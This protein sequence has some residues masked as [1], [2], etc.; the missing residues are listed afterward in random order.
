M[1]PRDDDA[2][3]LRVISSLANHVVEVGGIPV[4]NHRPIRFIREGSMNYANQRDPLHSHA[5]HHRHVFQEVLCIFLS[6]E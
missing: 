6:C 4:P 3:L 5:D 2:E 1:G